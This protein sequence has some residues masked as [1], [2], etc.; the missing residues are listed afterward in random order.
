[1]PL[2]EK[3]CRVEVR[4]GACSIAAI[5]RAV[6]LGQW[7][8]DLRCPYEMSKAAPPSILYPTQRC[9]TPGCAAEPTRAAVGPRN[10]VIES[11]LGHL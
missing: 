10:E 2:P 6:F 7:A 9:I 8:R 1:M 5:D 3:I 11:S 4:T